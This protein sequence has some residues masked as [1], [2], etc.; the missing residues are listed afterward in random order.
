MRHSEREYPHSAPHSS[1]KSGIEGESAAAAHTRDLPPRLTKLTPIRTTEQNHCCRRRHISGALLKK[2]TAHRRRH[3]AAAAIYCNI[4]RPAHTAQSYLPDRPSSTPKHL[5]EKATAAAE[6]ASPSAEVGR[7]RYP[8]HYCCR[9]STPTSPRQTTLP[10]SA[11][12][13][14]EGKLITRSSKL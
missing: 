11:T 14:K 2:T 7:Y 6:D 8:T 1:L 9:E 3:T 5:P 12:L 4:A 10:R 13:L